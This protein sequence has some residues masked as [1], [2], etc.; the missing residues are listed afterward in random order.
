VLARTGGAA[1]VFELFW[2]YGTRDFR[3][4]GHKI[5]YAANAW[6][7]LQTI[8]WRHGEPILRSLAYA[9]LAH[10][11][12]NPAGRSDDA[13]VPGRE[14]VARARR[15]RAAWQAGR[16]DA[17]AAGDLLTSMRTVTPAQACERIV[18]LLNR[19]ISPASLWDALFMSCGELLLRQPGIVSL[20]TLT[21]INAIYFAYQASGNDETR[22]WLLLQAA[23]FVPMFR[24]NMAG[25]GALGDLRIDTLA[26]Q[27]V[28]GAVAP[29]VEQIFAD[30][31]RDKPAAARKTLALLQA[32][33]VE[34]PQALMTAARRLIVSRGT[35]SHD[36]KFSS[37]VLEDFA[38]LTPAHRHRFMAASMF[39]LKG[40]GG[41]DTPLYRR[42]QAALTRS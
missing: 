41:Q 19:E 20:H 5:I 40:S 10:E 2:K 36:Y 38:H 13:D 26:R 33:P 6:R 37:A 17:A 14:N 32:H 12:T 3:A 23:A 42:I 18:D 31:S 4:I 35:D 29:A 39:W 1:D 24:Q 28:P 25:R 11:G 22:R 7:T 34:G 16:V 15:I 8:G 30:V 9:L 21:T 27:D